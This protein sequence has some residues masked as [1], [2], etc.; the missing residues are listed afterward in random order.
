MMSRTPA[1][2]SKIALMACCQLFAKYR[3]IRRRFSHLCLGAVGDLSSLDRHHDAAVEVF[4][5]IRAVLAFGVQLFG[6]DGVEMV[7]VNQHDVGVVAGGKLALAVTQTEQFSRAG[8][9]QEAQVFQRQAFQPAEFGVADAERG[10]QPHHTGRAARL[11]L[12][13]VGAWSVPMQLTV[14]S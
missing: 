13:R 8:A 6:F 10:L 3:R 12:H 5:V 2:H 9:H 4:P 1:A 11:V 14:P 7:K